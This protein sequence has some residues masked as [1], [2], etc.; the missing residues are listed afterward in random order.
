MM[1]VNLG[2]KPLADFTDPIQ[3]MKDCHRR[4]EHF[5]DVLRKV[6]TEFGEGDLPD[7]GRRALEASLNYFANFA[8]HH[9]ADEEQSL[10]PRMRS[11]Q[12]TQGRGAMENLDLL[13]R[14]HRRGEICH[15]SV[16]RLVRQWLEAG[17][18]DEPRRKSLRAALDELATMYAAHI[19]LE[20]QQVF[21]LAACTM[22]ATQLREIGLEMKRRRSLVGSGPEAGDA[23]E[24]RRTATIDRLQ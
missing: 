2:D 21:V 4:I 14:D 1:A 16:D 15:A 3:M 23:G 17:R 13:E 11:S 12:S 20:E 7:H 18:M 6:E 9:T 22:T 5:L 8:P 19:A 10:F 24:L